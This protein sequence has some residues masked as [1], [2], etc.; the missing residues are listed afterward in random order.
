MFDLIKTF[1]IGIWIEKK[2]RYFFI[3]I[4]ITIIYRI[5]KWSIVFFTFVMTPV[6]FISINNDGSLN[7]LFLKKYTQTIYPKNYQLPTKHGKRNK[8]YDT[9][10][11]DSKKCEQEFFK[12]YENA[13]Q[14]LINSSAEKKFIIY[15]DKK[16]PH[17]IG[18]IS[19]YNNLDL[20][21]FIYERLYDQ[22]FIFD[23]LSDVNYCEELK[24]FK[25]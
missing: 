18:D 5:V 9:H 20:E 19:Y 1:I 12:I 10:L 2:Y 16:V 3:F 6:T 17:K 22:G 4:T 14:H 11:Y 15:F 24:K 13:V 7:F 23:K 8:N 21:V 25:K